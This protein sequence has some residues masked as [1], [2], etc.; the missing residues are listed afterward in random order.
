MCDHY[1]LEKENFPKNGY[2][3]FNI[4]INDFGIIFIF[5]LELIYNI[6]FFRCTIQWLDVY[7]TY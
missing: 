6:I 2:N 4:S 5:Q 1:P 3:S 7:V